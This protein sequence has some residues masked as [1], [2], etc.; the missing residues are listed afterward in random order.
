MMLLVVLATLAPSIDFARPLP[1]QCA[2]YPQV[3]RLL[4]AN[5]IYTGTYERAQKHKHADTPAGSKLVQ[6]VELRLV[7]IAEGYAEHFRYASG[8][9]SDPAFFPMDAHIR[10]Q[11]LPPDVKAAVRWSL[12]RRHDLQRARTRR[13][14][15]ITRWCDS[16]RPCSA[17]IR[18]RQPEHVA[19][20][21]SG[22]NVACIAAFIDASGYPD[23]HVPHH[24]VYGF[25]VWSPTDSKVLRP[26]T[27][28]MTEQEADRM[29]AS[30]LQ[31]HQLTVAAAVQRVSR[32]AHAPERRVMGVFNAT[33]K[34]RAKR[35]IR[36]P[37]TPRQ[38]SARC[39]R[40]YLPMPRFGKDEGTKIRCIDD[41]PW[42]G[43]HGAARYVET[44]VHPSFT[45]PALVAA[46]VAKVEGRPVAMTMAFL[47]LLSAY[48]TVPTADPCLMVIATWNPRLKRVELYDHPGHVFGTGASV[49]NFQRYPALAVAMARTHCGSLAD[50]YVDD[51]LSPD[52]AEGAGTGDACLRTVV[53]AMGSGPR[54]PRDPIDAP[55]FDP[56]KD[57]PPALVN[58]GLGVVVNMT[59]LATRGVVTFHPTAKRRQKVMQLWHTH[60]AAASMTKH[61]APRLAG[62]RRFLMETAWGNV[63]R[64]ASQPLI[65]RAHH[66]G[67]ATSITPAIRAA[68]EFDSTLLSGEPMRLPPL[69]I[70]V[71]GDYRPPL[72]LYTDA[73]F[74]WRKKRKRECGVTQHDSGAVPREHPLPEPWQFDA[75]LGYALYDP[76][77]RFFE[78]AEGRPARQ[79]DPRLFSRGPG[80]GRLSESSEDSNKY[81]TAALTRCPPLTGYALSRS[82]TLSAPL[83]H[84]ARGAECFFASLQP[85]RMGGVLRA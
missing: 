80:P 47:D 2:A 68:Y 13:I 69:S 71:A 1:Q 64:A 15:S 73:S 22:V 7:P 31:S 21:A 61:D 11:A 44:V 67:S 17:A 5:R 36:G 33:S 56:G 53:E 49:I 25:P 19:H 8:K 76:E 10:P 37:Y 65:Q 54:H 75:R 58:E 35:L 3:V 72:L 42:A 59:A 48:K 74:R 27:P 83:A 40:G 4:R 63:G 39:P 57:K 81:F 84:R 12:A 28:T 14:A 18:V 16:L 43:V 32:D 26:I 29:Q 30:L 78:V 46:Y 79:T 20:I 24:M 41:G 45:Y 50:H 38:M 6:P 66:D 52:L 85:R 51:A 55:R 60:M 77:D 9:L 70:A 62:K 82:Q 34:E 23:T